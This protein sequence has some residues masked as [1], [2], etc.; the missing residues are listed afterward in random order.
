MQ[1]AFKIWLRRIF[2]QYNPVQKF[3]LQLVNYQVEFWVTFV[4]YGRRFERNIKTKSDQ[5]SQTFAKN[6][7]ATWQTTESQPTTS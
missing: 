7:P 5:S 3:Q 2:W 4:E 6:A 1:I